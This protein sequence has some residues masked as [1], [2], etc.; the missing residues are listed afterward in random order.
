MTFT[1]LPKILILRV[2]RSNY[3]KDKREHSKIDSQVNCNNDI[4]LPLGRDGPVIAYRLSSVI[5]HT[6]TPESGHY[7]ATL[8]DPATKKMWNCDDT[9]ITPTASVNQTTASILFYKKAE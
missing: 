1:D 8:C 5:H 2:N 3:D 6:G 4:S 7:T 9:K